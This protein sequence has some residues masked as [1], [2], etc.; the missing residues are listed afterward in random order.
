[1]FRGQRIR[2]KL[3]TVILLTSGVVLLMACGTFF[4]YDLLTYRQSTVRTLS[5]T[6]TGRVS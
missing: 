4:T 3:M 1:M 6:R 5:A 2:R